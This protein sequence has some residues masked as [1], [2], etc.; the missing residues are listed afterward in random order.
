MNKSFH[1]NWKG[2][3]LWSNHFYGLCAVL[4]SIE[5]AM[6]LLHQIPSIY[7]LLLIHLST[8][9]YY[10][11]AYLQEL[12]LGGDHERVVWYKNNQHYL[13]VRQA[14]YTVFCLFIAI[15]KM[16]LI[17]VI[18]NA[19]LFVKLILLVSGFLSISYYIPNLKGIALRSYRTKGVIKSIAIAW[20]WSFTCC[21][22]PV[23]LGSI[24][25]MFKMDEQFA[26][27]FFHL[28]IYVL[29]LAI[30]FDIKD[31]PMDLKDTVNTIAVRLGA[32]KTV[33][34]IID[35]LLVLYYFIIIYWVFQM[36]L[37]TIHLLTHGI[38]VLLTYFIARSII[39]QKVIYLNILLIDGLLVIKALLGI[40]VIGYCWP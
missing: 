11:H 18:L 38:L 7:L 22:I 33:K 20:V 25:Y 36:G 24:H 37:P 15:V 39:Q 10:T 14:V 16:D 35:P 5:S 1:I 40:A 17:S 19:S 2:I 30:L 4:L 12:K 34:Q 27:Y 13:K 32:E 28:F 9:V 29:I 31:I 6:M 21:F 3:F 23:W 26:M 8:V